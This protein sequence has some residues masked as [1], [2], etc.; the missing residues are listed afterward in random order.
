MPKF[1][2]NVMRIVYSDTTIEID[3]EDELDA[4]LK[5][6]DYVK[7]HEQDFDFEEY[8]WFWHGEVME[9]RE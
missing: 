5:A 6:S 1:L 4:Q 8:D 9:R 3:G 2:V 7:N